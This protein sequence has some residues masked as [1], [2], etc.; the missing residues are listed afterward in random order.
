M[1]RSA[2]LTFFAVG[3]MLLA[4][5]HGPAAKADGV[6]TCTKASAQGTDVMNCLD[7]LV[8]QPLP[9]A[10]TTLVL[11]CPSGSPGLQDQSRCPGNV[12][13]PLSTVLPTE[14]VGY[15][16]QAQLTPYNVCDYPSGSE[17]Y[18]VA[19]AIF[20]S[21]PEAPSDP[22]VGAPSTITWGAPP[23]NV[24]GSQTAITG[25]RIEYGMGDFSHS[26]TTDSTANSYT[27]TNLAPGTWQ[28]RVI[29][30]SAGT[31]SA[32][33]TT[34]TFQVTSGGA[35]ASCGA[36]PASATQTV[37]CPTGYTGSWTQTLGW[38]SAA[39]PTCW[40]AQPWTPTSPPAGAC[41]AVV[42][43]W[44]VSGTGSQPVYEAVLPLSG[45]TLVRGMQQGTVVAGTTCG[46]E[47]FRIGTTSYRQIDEADASLA[48]PT[49]LGRSHT[50]V[51]AQQ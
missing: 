34:I 49:Y 46:N 12:W 10:S 51:C 31:E 17:G 41:T 43:P 8:Y 19:S 13:K 26:V 40:V 25:Y 50:A 22:G 7:Q 14:L 21:V 6:T 39:A 2:T 16:A 33:S 35:P 44:V 27:L 4:L 15:C 45:S 29:A 5:M 30:L 18:R 3:F 11:T 24:D 38:S 37:A 42:Q 36:A 47:V 48:S 28:A 32:P 9:I 20:G 23:Q 1:R